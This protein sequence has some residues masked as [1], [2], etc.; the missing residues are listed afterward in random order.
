L[1]E[2]HPKGSVIE[3]WEQ[4]GPPDIEPHEIILGEKLGE[5]TKSKKWMWWE[6]IRRI[7]RG[8]VCLMNAVE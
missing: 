1:Q 7:R 2:S 3:D 4:S 5:G 8:D 6:D